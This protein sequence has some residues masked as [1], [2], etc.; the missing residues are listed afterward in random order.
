MRGTDIA[1]GATTREE[2]ARRLSERS[3]TFLLPGL[4]YE[5]VRSARGAMVRCAMGL[6]VCYAMCGT[7]LAYAAMGLRVSYDMA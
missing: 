7:G 4:S 2:A 1:Y 5:T 3:W 6:C